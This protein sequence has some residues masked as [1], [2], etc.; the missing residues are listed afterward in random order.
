MRRRD[1]GDAGTAEFALA[2]H[3]GPG[4]LGR[5]QAEDREVVVGLHGIM[6][7]G[8]EAG[9][10]DGLRQG[11]VAGAH[12][13]GAVHPG[14]RADGIGDT[15][16]RDGFQHQPVDGVHGQVWAGSEQL[17]RGG[18]GVLRRVGVGGGCGHGA[19]R[20]SGA[21]VVPSQWR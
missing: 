15:A 10:S 19:Q 5:E 4:A 12:G 21:A 8:I 20:I 18:I 3:V 14:G 6:Q 7:L 9:G 13:A 2:D 16:Q 17:G 11:A 1:A